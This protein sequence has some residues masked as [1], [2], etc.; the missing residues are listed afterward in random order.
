MTPGVRR[1]SLNLPTELVHEAQEALGT[2]GTTDTVL[3]AMRE[4][5]RLRRR[6]RLL[7]YD[8]SSLTDEVIDRLRQP[9]DDG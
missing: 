5:V 4:A 1:T 2:H 8:T 7:T 9:R 6:L 3:A